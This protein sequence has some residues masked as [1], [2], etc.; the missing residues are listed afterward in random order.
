MRDLIEEEKTIKDL[1][2]GDIMKTVATFYGITIDD[3]LSSQ[4]T[5]TLVTPRQLAM[6]L[7][8]KLTTKSLQEIADEFKKTHATVLH[9]AQTI[10]KRLD[11]EPDL[12]KSMED[13]VSQMGRKAS[14]IL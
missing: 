3:I 8:R 5:Q 10:Q 2:I 11:V 9:G 13:I 7:S 14:D 6:F 4:R 1:S 12:K